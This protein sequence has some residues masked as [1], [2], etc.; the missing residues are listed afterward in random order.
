MTPEPTLPPLYHELQ[1][2]L[3]LASILHGQTPGRALSAPPGAARLGLVWFHSRVFL[4][5]D[6][7]EAQLRQLAAGWM[8][9]DLLPDLTAA[10]QEAF[11]LHASPPG[12]LARLD[13]LLPGRQAI[14]AMR[15]YY[16]CQALKED[17]RRLTPAEFEMCPVTAEL[18]TRPGLGGLEALREE[19]CSERPSVE[20]F[21]QKSY[22][23]ALV[24]QNEVV[25][26]CLSEYNLGGR[27]EVGV[28]TA[29]ALRG[30]GLGTAMSLALVE[31]ALARGCRQIGWH[32][33]QR[34]LASAA[35][36]RRA[37]FQ[38]AGQH[39]VVI[40]LLKEADG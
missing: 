30:R 16:T 23:V 18:L 6:P 38:L 37:G 10:G 8:Q 33:W 9:Q 14:H 3:A 35:L 24:H 29:E 31:M 21:L 28:A 26:W 13:D 12:W 1:D 34:N 4:A 7:D 15:E 2:H 20:D 19:M 25:G 40:Y 36:A 11:V 27:C 17:W 32:C 22:G 5:G 39:P